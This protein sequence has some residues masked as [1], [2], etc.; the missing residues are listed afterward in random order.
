MSTTKRRSGQ[1]SRAEILNS[2]LTFVYQ[3]SLRLGQLLRIA[4]LP[5]QLHHIY[6]PEE[7]LGFEEPTPHQQDVGYLL[8]DWRQR[9]SAGVHVLE[10]RLPQVGVRREL[11]APV[12]QFLTAASELPKLGTRTKQAPMRPGFCLQ[13]KP[14]IPADFWELPRQ[15]IEVVPPIIAA[16]HDVSVGLTK[17]GLPYSAH[18]LAGQ[19]L[20]ANAP[21]AVPQDPRNVY[22]NNVKGWNAFASV[23]EGDVCTSDEIWLENPSLIATISET[24]CSMSE[25]APNIQ[26][27]DPTLAEVMKRLKAVLAPWLR[28]ELGVKQLTRGRDL[29]STT[30]RDDWIRQ[31]SKEKKSQSELIEEWEKMSEDEQRQKTGWSGTLSES[32]IKGAKARAKREELDSTPEKIF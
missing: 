13:V 22:P 1:N 12:R 17:T 4:E 16:L 21:F 29:R 8:V 2:A 11:S 24:G 28:V 5:K 6:E 23:R 25:F 14:E 20:S 31:R 9:I 19:L 27:N 15:V 30:L 3:V 26:P 18:F 7:V 10:R 32:I